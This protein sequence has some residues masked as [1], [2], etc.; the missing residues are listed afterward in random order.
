MERSHLYYGTIT[1]LSG[2]DHFQ[3]KGNIPAGKKSSN[4]LVSLHDELLKD[5][6]QV[7]IHSLGKLCRRSCLCMLNPLRKRGG[8][9]VEEPLAQRPPLERY[10]I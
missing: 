8:R 5:F 1:F 7:I 9:S 4:D 3:G 10:G 6:L 2:K